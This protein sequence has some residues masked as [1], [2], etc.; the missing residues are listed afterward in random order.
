MSYQEFIDLRERHAAIRITFAT[1]CLTVLWMVV[2]FWVYQV[3]VPDP[4]APPSEEKDPTLAWLTDTEATFIRIWTPSLFA[5]PADNPLARPPLVIPGIPAGNEAG[6]PLAEGLPPAAL[7]PGLSRLDYPGPVRPLLAFA[8][9]APAFL[10]DFPVASPAPPVL[11]GERFFRGGVFAEWI[12]QQ[13]DRRNLVMDPETAAEIIADVDLR[14]EVVFSASRDDRG[15]L[16]HLRVE[17]G[18]TPP[19]L[20]ARIRTWASGQ[21]LPGPG[22]SSRGTLRVHYVPERLREAPPG[23]GDR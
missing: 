14:W 4:G 12:G 15:W 22:L 17:E 8:Q 10:V 5:L 18:A 6:R 3:H 7:P 16:D 20:T 21:H 11:S 2:W 1:A 19:E 23:G 13:G 9:P